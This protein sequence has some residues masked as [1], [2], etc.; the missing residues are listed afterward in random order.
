VGTFAGAD[1]PIYFDS[2]NRRPITIESAQIDGTDLRVLVPETVVIGGQTLSVPR[3]PSIS[4]DGRTVAFHMSRAGAGAVLMQCAVET[5]A[6]SFLDFGRATPIEGAAV[7]LSPDGEQ[8]A[9]VNMS[10][11]IPPPIDPIRGGVGPSSWLWIADK[12]GVRIGLDLPPLGWF[13]GVPQWS[14]DG[15]WI[16]VAVMPQSPGGT[17]QI[18]LVDPNDPTNTR[19]VAEQ[20]SMST[21][22]GKPSGR[23]K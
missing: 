18:Q 4:A 5:G 21:P 9:F 12:N 6:V 17:S 23:T 11:A 13:V 19:V 1:G 3:Q 7:S 20:T 2:G 16:A 15:R 10:G 22:T 8:V 14:P